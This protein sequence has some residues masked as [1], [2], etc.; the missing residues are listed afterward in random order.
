M[1]DAFS[2]NG[3]FASGVATSVPRAL[4]DVPWVSL[5]TSLKLSMVPSSKTICRFFKNEPSCS[6]MNPNVYEFLMSLI[7]PAIFT[8]RPKYGSGSLY[9]CFISS[10]NWYPPFGISVAAYL[11]KHMYSLKIYPVM[12]AGYH[13]G[14]FQ[15]TPALY[16]VLLNQV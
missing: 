5:A 16:I 2:S 3:C 1:A 12:T 7:Q 13:T 6:S 10:F 11:L 9:N 15:A 14:F 8:S 4:I